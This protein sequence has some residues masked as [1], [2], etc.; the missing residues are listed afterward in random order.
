RFGTVVKDLHFQASR[1]LSAKR[2]QQALDRIDDLD[3]IRA[4]LALD[5]EHDAAFVVEPGGELVVFHTVDDAADFRE[6]HGRAIPIGDHDRAKRRRI[7]QLAV[8]FDCVGAICAVKRAGWQVGVVPVDCIGDLVD[9]NS[10]RSQRFGV[11]LNAHRVFLG[12]NDR[13]LRDPVDGRNALRQQGL[14]IF[15]YRRHGQR[16]RSQR[17]IENGRVGG[18][19]LLKGRRCGHLRRQLFQSPSDGGLHVRGG[20]VDVA[21]ERELQ[22]NAADALRVGGIHRIEA[23]NR[24]ERVLQ[25]RGGGGRGGGGGRAGGRRGGRGGGGV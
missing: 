23:G 3:G 18:V 16:R 24:G 2:R 12:T 19:D 13:H 15:V 11:E 4:R 25:R 21:V 14:C 22:R 10:A 1:R 6:A 5:G 9:A 7:Q 17:K 8:G 20:G